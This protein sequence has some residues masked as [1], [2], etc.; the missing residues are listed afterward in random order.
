MTIQASLY[1]TWSEPK[2]LV[3]SRTGSF[4]CHVSALA[5]ASKTFYST[6]SE[7]YEADWE[8]HSQVNEI[9]QVSLTH[10]PSCHG[11]CQILLQLNNKFALL[12]VLLSYL[13]EEIGESR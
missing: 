9:L 12:Q 1:R 13:V 10:K 2:L 6:L 11:G 7:T 4:L 5:L 3:F 8:G